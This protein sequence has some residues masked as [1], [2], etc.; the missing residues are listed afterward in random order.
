MSRTAELLLEDKDMERNWNIASDLM[1]KWAGTMSKPAFI[2]F[3]SNGYVGADKPGGLTCFAFSPPRKISYGKKDRK[4][5]L[6]H[7]LGAKK[8]LEEED[9][10]FYARYDYYIP[11]TVAEGELQIKMCLRFL[12][13]MTHPDSIAAQGH[14]HAIDL[15]DENRSEFYACQEEDSMFMAKYVNLVDTV[16]RNFCQRLSHYHDY[17]QP[18]RRARRE[19]SN[20]MR[21][22]ID[23]IM[24]DINLEMTPILPLPPKLLQGGK[25]GKERGSDLAVG[26]NSGSG[27]GTN[28]SPEWWSKNPCVRDNWVVPE[29]KKLGDFFNRDTDEGKANRALLPRA[30]HH[31]PKISTERGLCMRYQNGSCAPN[32]GLSHLPPDRMSPSLIDAMDKAIRQIYKTT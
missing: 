8:E 22:D 13:M 19:L 1:C 20:K 25:Q 4:R 9:L 7:V 15:L 26:G 11:Q 5:A 23:R 3:L 27:G 31:N 6:R 16:F 2:Q 29:G 24:G 18:V 21:E 30:K 28:K 10:E 12:E 17:D 32:C 14:Y